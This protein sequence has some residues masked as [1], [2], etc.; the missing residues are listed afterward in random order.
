MTES[1]LSLLDAFESLLE[2]NMNEFGNYFVLI[3]ELLTFLLLM[4]ILFSG[5]LITC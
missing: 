5:F 4:I 1:L 2:L 3:A